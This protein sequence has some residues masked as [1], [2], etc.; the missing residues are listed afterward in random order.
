MDKEQASAVVDEIFTAPQVEESSQEETKEER[1]PAL[2]TLLYEGELKRESAEPKSDTQRRKNQ[3]RLVLSL[4]CIILAAVGVIIYGVSVT[5][6]LSRGTAPLEELLLSEVLGAGIASLGHSY[7]LPPL[8]MIPPQTVV[9][10]ESPGAAEEETVTESESPTVTESAP[11]RVVDLSVG[12]DPFAIINETP[13]AP[14]TLALYYSK[15]EIPTLGEIKKAH[16]KSAPAVLIL[17]T[18][19]TE[20]Y[21]ASGVDTVSPEESFRSAEAERSVVAVG[22]RMKRVLEEHGIGVIHTE[23]M[24]DLTDYNSAYVRAAEHIVKMREKYPSIAYV[25]DVHRDAMV[26]SE[27]VHLKPTSPNVRGKVNPAQIMLVV[28]PDHA[29][30]G[31][32]GWETNLSLALKLQAGALAIDP[33]LMRPINLRSASFNQQYV[34]GSLIVEVGAAAGTLEEALAAG[35]IFAEAVAKAIVDS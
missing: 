19:G 9:D 34:K 11:V 17:H 7:S 24:F 5:G 23:E 6:S 27:G 8:N 32:V 33:S 20:S 2:S 26:T 15:S 14:D 28:G 29:G 4:I 31:R 30:S 35:E 10:G 1:L 16:G 21:L 3:G 13:Y 12:E 25:F 22:R 18:H